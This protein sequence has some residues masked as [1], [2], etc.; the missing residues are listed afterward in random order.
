MN[1]FIKGTEVLANVKQMLR[2]TNS[3]SDVW[4][5][6][7]IL[8]GSR[9]LTTVETLIIKNCTIEVQDNKFYLPEDAKMMIAF[10]ST[11]SCIPGVFVDIP[12]F[13]H[14]G[15]NENIGSSLVNIIDINGRWAHLLNSVPDGTEIEIAYVA[16]D[17]DSDGMPKINEEAYTALSM[18]AAGWYAVSY[19]EIY[20]SFQCNMWLNKYELQAGK[21]RSL[22]AR[23]KF[24]Q[25]KEQIQRKMHM[26]CNGNAPIGAIAGTYSSFFYP[27]V[28]NI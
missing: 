22:A 21:C 5:E 23:R 7:L 28:W 10:R 13:K 1:A 12:F 2:I 15:C 27:T 18:Y 17:T 3:D 20:S 11:D 4:L 14:C 6:S 9:D 16:V 26:M 19:P 24:E 25:Q 8:R